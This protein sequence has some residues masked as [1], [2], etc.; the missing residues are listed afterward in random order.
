MVREALRLL[1]NFMGITTSLNWIAEPLNVPC[2]DPNEFF[3]GTS[4]KS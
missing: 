4:V 2:A 1:L 3:R